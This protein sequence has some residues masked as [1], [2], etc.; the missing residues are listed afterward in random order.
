VAFFTASALDQRLDL[1]ALWQ[2]Q[3]QALGMV[4]NA[5]K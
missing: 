3:E 4:V 1:P 2:A 5:R